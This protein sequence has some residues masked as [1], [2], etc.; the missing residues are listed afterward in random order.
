MRETFLSL[1][2]VERNV[3]EGFEGWINFSL[4]IRVDP[5]K[6]SQ[7]NIHGCKD[8]FIA[9]SKP[10][11][12]VTSAYR[13]EVLGKWIQIKD[14]YA[15]RLKPKSYSYNGENVISGVAR[16]ERWTNIWISD[17]KKVFHKH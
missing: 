12:G 13:G 14:V 11:L 16:P 9:E 8:I 15:M 7:I 6:L 1:K 3:S 4:N 5:E 10:T 17:P 2:T